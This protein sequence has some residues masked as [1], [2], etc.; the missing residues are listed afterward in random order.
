MAVR[1]AAAAPPRGR[2]VPHLRAV[3][4]AAE[5]RAGTAPP[6]RAAP[7]GWRGDAPH[8]RRR[9][10]RGD[11]HTARGGVRAP[12]GGWGGAGRRAGPAPRLRFALEWKSGGSLCGE[13]D[14]ERCAPL[15]P[16]GKRACGAGAAEAG[17]R[18]GTRREGEHSAARQPCRSAPPAGRAGGGRASRMLLRAEPMNAPWVS[19]S[20]NAHRR[21]CHRK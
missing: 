10:R 12:R 21:V 7:R 13:H 15:A 4:A 16:P 1:R 3:A 5:V 11:T 8:W 14:G 19:V 20:R 18:T 2:R 17:S 6:R 9:W